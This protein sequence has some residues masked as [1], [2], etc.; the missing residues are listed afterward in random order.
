MQIL[1]SSGNPL[2]VQGKFDRWVA[3]VPYNVEREAMQFIGQILQAA[4][5]MHVNMCEPFV[6]KIRDDTTGNYINAI[7]EVLS[8]QSPDILVCMVS[9]NRS[10][11][12]SAIKKKCC[13]ER[14]GR[15]I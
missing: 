15:I 5:G 9:N 6:H 13:V 3:I 11:R 12:Y 4:R 2:L 7:E 14:S 8:R 10:D 1:I